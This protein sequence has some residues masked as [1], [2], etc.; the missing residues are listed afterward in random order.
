LTRREELAAFA[1][2]RGNCLLDNF[3]FAPASEAFYLAHQIA[4]HKQCFDDAWGLAFYSAKIWEQ[5]TSLPPKLPEMPVAEAI[6]RV[7]AGLT[8]PDVNIF[9]KP[10]AQN[11]LRI[12][13]NRK[14]KA[15]A[16]NHAAVFQEF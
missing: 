5:I 16:S 2:T 12:M 4:P 9:R 15:Q 1:A 6:H 10:S 8:G 13:R 14:R 11:L 7:A 3:N